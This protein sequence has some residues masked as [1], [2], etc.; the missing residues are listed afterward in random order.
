[1]IPITPETVKATYEYLLNFPP[2]CKWKM[3]AA[4][5]LTFLVTAYKTEYAQYDHAKK[6]LRVSSLNV[7]KQQ[8]LIKKIA[9]EMIHVHEDAL[10]RNTVKH[11]S[12]FFFRCR[13]RV[14]K[15]FDFDPADF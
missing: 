7:S 13:D 2:F 11:D 4:R 3:H 10:N 6:A 14:C 5:N 12:V 8:T 1:M 9:H 15:H